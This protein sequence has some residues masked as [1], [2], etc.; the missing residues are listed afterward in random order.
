MYCKMDVH[1][2]N[3]IILAN[4]T[5]NM[6]IKPKKKENKISKLNMSTCSISI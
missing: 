2:Y 4:L 3:C 6:L 5:I 1:A